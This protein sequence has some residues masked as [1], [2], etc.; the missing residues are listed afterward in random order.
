MSTITISYWDT[1]CL[2]KEPGGKKLQR[3]KLF[4]K[5]THENFKSSTFLSQSL[6]ESKRT[7]KEAH[8]TEHAGCS[9]S[10]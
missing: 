3:P 9:I 4:I 10:D 2:H 1:N 8:H 7:D 5:P 6:L